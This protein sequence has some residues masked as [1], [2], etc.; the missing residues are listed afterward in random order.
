MLL[1]LSQAPKCHLQKQ[2]IVILLKMTVNKY[3]GDISVVCSRDTMLK[4][5]WSSG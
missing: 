2:K 3:S 5:L 4:E 1:I